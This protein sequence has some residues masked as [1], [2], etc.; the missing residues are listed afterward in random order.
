MAGSEV[1]YIRTYVLTIEIARD[2]NLLIPLTPDVCTLIVI[3]EIRW[4]V[5]KMYVR[6]YVLTS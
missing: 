5:R 2:L 3:W 1:I 6:T 4:L